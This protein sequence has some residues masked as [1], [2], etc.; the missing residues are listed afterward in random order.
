VDRH[1]RI[2]HFVGLSRRVSTHFSPSHYVSINGSEQRRELRIIQNPPPWALPHRSSPFLR[3]YAYRNSSRPTRRVPI[4][5]FD[6]RIR[7]SLLS[8][9]YNSFSTYRALPAFTIHTAVKQA[10]KAFTNVQNP[11][12]KT[13]G[14]T[15]TGLAIV[16]VLPYLF[17]HPVEHVTDRVFDWI[18]EKLIEQRK[19]SSTGKDEL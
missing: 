7:I 14:P 8:I 4:H 11:R 17:D 1:R 3:T 16:P 6:V 13:W 5:R 15:M 19:G 12:V 10:K 2:W 18:R 9:I